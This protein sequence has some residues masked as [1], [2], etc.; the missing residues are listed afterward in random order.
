MSYARLAERLFNVPLLIAP[1]KADTIAA[2][3]NAHLQNTV[4][5]L[6]KFEPPTRV[7]LATSMSMRRA[8]GGYYATNAGVAVV[9]AHGSFVQRAGGLD[10]QSGLTGY[11]SIAATLSAAVRDPGVRGVVIEFDS[12][13][14]EVEGVV[15]LASLIAGVDKPVWAHANGIALSAAYW[16]A[17]AAD[18][19]YASQT[20]LLGSIGVLL[21]HADRSKII[22]RSGVV[23]TAIYAGARKVD[24]SSM[25]P[26]TEEARARAQA[27]VDQVY[28]M[29][30]EHVA[31]H[32]SVAEKKVRG[33]EAAILSVQDAK[34]VGLANDVAS[35][36]DT[37]QMMTDDLNAGRSKRKSYGRA[38]ANAHS[39]QETAMSEQDNG[40]AP[41]E[42]AAI[43]QADLD[44]A[45]AEG[46]EKGKKEAA[47]EAQAT[48]AKQADAT[49]GDKAKARIKAIQDSPEGKERPALAK[50]LAFDT[51][52]TS[53]A[54]QAFMK[55]MPKEASGN[56]LDAAMRGTNPKVGADGEPPKERGGAHVV[57]MKAIYDARHPHLRAQK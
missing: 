6:P 51:D 26:L 14:G 44:K 13:G 46:V 50:K 31:A 37:V 42:P 18:R 11:N 43:T 9:Q 54:A 4:A 40:A 21:L 41:K 17:A 24:G 30:T 36:G 35:L 3:F 23:Y 25:S 53:E 20:G 49:A 32:R 10:A 28:A 5:E 34:Q 22:E 2:V 12:P 47:T 33:T 1:D 45:R 38:A 48:A 56:P 19:V 15:D 8:D 7:D 27:R 55:D 29:F 52:M 39:S 57:D 16:L